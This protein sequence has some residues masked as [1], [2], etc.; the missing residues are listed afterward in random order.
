MNKKFKRFGRE[1]SNYG[2]SAQSDDSSK[3]EVL[4]DSSEFYGLGSGLEELAKIEVEE[5]FSDVIMSIVLSYVPIPETEEDTCE[6]GQVVAPVAKVVLTHEDGCGEE[7][8]REMEEA[9]VAYCLPHIMSFTL[10][11][12]K[13]KGIY[14]AYAYMEDGYMNNPEYK[15]K[16][17]M[18][19]LMI[20]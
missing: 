18:T 9:A 1:K 15:G 20:K 16:M 13:G 2:C 19:I 12:K 5:D 14:R 3:V 8:L 6:D 11:F 10:G 17:D 7:E 4:T